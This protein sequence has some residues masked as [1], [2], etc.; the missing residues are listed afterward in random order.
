MVVTRGERVGRRRGEMG[1]GGMWLN[2]TGSILSAPS[3]A[4]SPTGA[5][6]L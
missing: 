1:K 3:Q 4:H 6:P 2:H 5:P